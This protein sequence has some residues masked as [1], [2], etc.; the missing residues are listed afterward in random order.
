MM[1]NFALSH[2]I[3]LLSQARNTSLLRPAQSSNIITSSPYNLPPASQNHFSLSLSRKKELFLPPP[4]NPLSF[5]SCLSQ[6]IQTPLAILTQKQTPLATLTR[7][8]PITH[9]TQT[10]LSSPEWA[11][12][13]NT[14]PSM[15]RH[16]T[17]RRIE[18]A[19]PGLMSLTDILAKP[20]PE[21]DQAR[22]LLAFSNTPQYKKDC[23]ALFQHMLAAT[24][25]KMNMIERVMSWAV[26]RLRSAS[27]QTVIRYISMIAGVI[28]SEM[29]IDISSNHTIKN[30]T[31]AL[32]RISG[33]H[34]EFTTTPM[35][36]EE[37]NTLI[38]LLP[39]PFDA[40][41]TLA[42]RKAARIQDI[43][44]TRVGGLWIGVLDPTDNPPTSKT[45]PILLESPWDKVSWMGRTNVSQLLLS[46]K[47]F[48]IIQAFISPHP[49]STPPRFRPLLFPE[50][51][52]THVREEI[53]RI[54]PHLSTRSIR[55]GAL[56]T[57]VSEGVP[58]D[59]CRLLSFHRSLDGL[60]R[61]VE[62]PDRKTTNKMI[63]MQNILGR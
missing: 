58:L 56:Q 45:I 31:K 19:R 53:K 17:H 30:F 32:R 12:Y 40:I 26:I 3:N 61:Y 2:K 54:L 36:R 62:R 21:L 51:T 46:A 1:P 29:M 8:P 9:R 52:T 33:D 44:E 35:T 25:S 41:I 27:A 63:E 10:I 22:L 13:Q 4:T 20:L 47:E 11:I 24:D 34:K 15:P 38:S 49:P 57:L 39:P 60:M 37:M 42:W 23:M 5:L 55:R 7:S 18:F 28:R 14:P 43:L 16:V 50:I 59:Q 48:Q 6:K